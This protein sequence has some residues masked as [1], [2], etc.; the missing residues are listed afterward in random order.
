MFALL[1]R[2]INAAIPVIA[3]SSGNFFYLISFTSAR[4]WAGYKFHTNVQNYN[5]E[6]RRLL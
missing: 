6:E 4:H 3:A 1:A 2:I 5:K